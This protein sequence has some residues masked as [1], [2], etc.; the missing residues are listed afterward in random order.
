MHYSLEIKDYLHGRSFTTEIY[1]IKI[2]AYIG[3]LFFQG[4]IRTLCLRLNHRGMLLFRYCMY[5]FSISG[6]IDRSNFSKAFF[7]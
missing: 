5:H 7:S 6:L 3:Y 1:F 2:V 4:I